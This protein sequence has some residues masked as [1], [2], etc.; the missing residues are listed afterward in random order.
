MRLILLALALLVATFPVDAAPIRVPAK[1]DQLDI[2][3]RVSFR[4]T[5]PEAK[6]KETI[7]KSPN[8]EWLSY[9]NS[10]LRRVI[11]NGDV[12]WVRFELV[13]NGTTE[14]VVWLGQP[15]AMLDRFEV[16]LTPS[17]G[18]ETRH[19]IVGQQVDRAEW[20]VNT[21]AQMLPIR[22]RPGQPVQILVRM[23]G[24]SRIEAKLTLHEP[25]AWR[26]EEMLIGVFD[27]F[28][29][30]AIVVMMVYHFML[31]R[32]ITGLLPL[33]L[34]NHFFPSASLRCPDCES[35]NLRSTSAIAISTASSFA[36]LL[37]SACIDCKALAMSIK[38]SRKAGMD[39]DK[40]ASSLR[41]AHTTQPLHP[42]W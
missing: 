29:Y 16:W 42:R 30:G 8:Y 24:A 35:R 12:L 2:S 27:A 38:I 37:D 20:P 7:W 9:A 19:L 14:R 4:I 34:G 3:P 33:L 22:L 21:L 36:L 40:L 26:A 10:K 13:N 18:G 6:D 1:L 11:K 32:T 28:T 25:S 41:M 23:A 5:S 17:G 39:A 31:F 15:L